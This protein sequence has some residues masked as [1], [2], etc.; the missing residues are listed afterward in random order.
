MYCSGTTAP[1]TLFV[2]VALLAS[3]PVATQ[4]GPSKEILMEPS[5][6]PLGIETQL[7]STD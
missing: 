1:M 4:E 2:F 7:D 3:C 5:W 6:S